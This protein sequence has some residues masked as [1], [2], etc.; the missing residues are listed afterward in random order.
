MNDRGERVLPSL[1]IETESH[2]VSDRLSR[3]APLLLE[4]LLIAA[5]VFLFQIELHRHFFPVLCLI[6]IGFVLHTWLPS[7]RRLAFFAA[8]SAVCIVFVI[9]MVNGAS[10]IAIGGVLLCLCYLPLPWPMRTSLLVIAGIVL[11]VLRTSISVALVARGGFLLHVSADQ[12]YTRTSAI[13]VIA[14][15]VFVTGLF[16]DVAECLLSIISGRRFQ[17]IPSHEI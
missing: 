15:V 12:L 11:V 10:V 1:A 14:V 2:S 3:F 8:L 7:E 5:V 4:L 16:S 9:G 17:D 13:Q 6:T